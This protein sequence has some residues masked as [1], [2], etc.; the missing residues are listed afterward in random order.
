MLLNPDASRV[1]GEAG[2][3]PSM[4]ERHYLAFEGLSKAT[5]EAWFGIF[6]PSS[7]R[8]II[9]LEQPRSGKK[10]SPIRPQRLKP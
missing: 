9:L 7:E 1:A 2:N 8:Q 6:P 5:A 10:S 4:L 3:S